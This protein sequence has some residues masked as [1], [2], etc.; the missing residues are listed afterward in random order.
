MNV[1]HF[2]PSLYGVSGGPS[3]SYQSL[4]ENLYAGGEFKITA[5]YGVSKKL[6][7]LLLKFRLPI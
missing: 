5:L 2:I 3:V 6:V 4:L 1:L 7:D